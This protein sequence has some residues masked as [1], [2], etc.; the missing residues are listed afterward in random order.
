MNTPLLNCVLRVFQKYIKNKTENVPPSRHKIRIVISKHKIHSADLD[1]CPTLYYINEI[2]LYSI[3]F[4]S[5]HYLCRKNHSTA[6]PA[7]RL[8]QILKVGNISFLTASCK[9]VLMYKTHHLLEQP[10]S[11]TIGTRITPSR[12]NV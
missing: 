3:I 4:H 10:F 6:K 8:L 12:R 11:E 2:T 1:L 5:Y 9:K 7:K